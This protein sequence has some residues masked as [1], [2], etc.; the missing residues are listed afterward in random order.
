MHYSYDITVIDDQRPIYGFLSFN[1]LANFVISSN[2]QVR[3]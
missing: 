3:K 1:A 2:I